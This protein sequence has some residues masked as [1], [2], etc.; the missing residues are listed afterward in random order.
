MLHLKRGGREGVLISNFLFADDTLLFSNPCLDQLTYLAWL[1]LWF[2]A[3]SV[4]N[5]NLSKSDLIPIGDVPNV[6]ELAS[7]MGC[8]A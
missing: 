6:G 5:I 1:L 8:V 4:L 7:V 2:E 3:S